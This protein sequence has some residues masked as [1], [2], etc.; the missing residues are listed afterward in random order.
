MRLIDTGAARRVNARK[1]AMSGMSTPTYSF[2]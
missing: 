2:H 1:R